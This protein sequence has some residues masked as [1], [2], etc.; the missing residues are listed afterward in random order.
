MCVGA[1]ALDGGW[2][3]GSW[4]DG[5]GHEDDKR[6]PGFSHDEAVDVDPAEAA[7]VSC[8]VP[9]PALLLSPGLSLQADLLSTAGGGS[10]ASAC[11]VFLAH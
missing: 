7:L 9:V 8:P 10:P 5:G 1:E 4:V 2:Y 3:D 11:R 6:M